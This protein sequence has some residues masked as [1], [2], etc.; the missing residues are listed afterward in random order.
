MSA[1][2]RDR[3]LGIWWG[4]RSGSQG[5]LS[6]RLPPHRRCL[7]LRR[8]YSNVSAGDSRSETS[9]HRTSRRSET[10]SRRAE[11]LE[12]ISSSRRRYVNFRGLTVLVA[13]PHVNSC[14]IRF[15]PRKTL[16]RA[17]M[18]RCLASRH[19]IW[20]STSSTGARRSHGL[21]IFNADERDAGRLRLRGKRQVPSLTRL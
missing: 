7:G 14:G 21:A 17:W 15:M 16:S 1:H 18:N 19:R 3:R 11:F 6:R 4:S 13:D 9:A 5:S 2:L 8:T 10:R 20:T 12:R